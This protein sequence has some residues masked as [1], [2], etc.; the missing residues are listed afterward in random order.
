MTGAVAGALVALAGLGLAVLIGRTLGNRWRDWILGGV[1]GGCGVG[2]LQIAG[3]T[4][5]GIGWTAVALVVYGALAGAVCAAAS[6][7]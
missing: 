3:F 6:R 7:R 5:L 4:D 2:A 1:I